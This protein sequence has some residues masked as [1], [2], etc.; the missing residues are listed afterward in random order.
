[1]K[2]TLCVL[3]ALLMIVTLANMACAAEK[4]VKLTVPG[5]FS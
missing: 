1:M 2:K 5:C 4:I 3:W